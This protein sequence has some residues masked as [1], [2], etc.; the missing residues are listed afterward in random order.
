MS[1]QINPF[2]IFGLTPEIASRLDEKS[3][4]TLIKSLYRCLAKVYHPDL[5]GQSGQE[6]LAAKQAARTVE[7]NLA[8]EQLNLERDRD[9]FRRFHKAYANRTNRGQRKKIREL[10]KSLSQERRRQASLADGFVLY[11]LREMPWF[12]AS[13]GREAGPNLPSPAN[14]KLGLNDVAINHNIRGASWNLG[15]NYKEIIFDALGGMLYRPVGRSH[16]FSVNFIH[17]LGT[18]PVEEIDLVPLLNRMPPKEGFF[19]RAAL[20]SRYGMDGAPIEVLNTLS[21]D[22]FK[23]HCLSRLQPELRERS[24]LFSVHRPI[25]EETGDIS[26]E[27]VVVK[28]SGL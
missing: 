7:L 4:F 27:G 19:K 21:M 24:Y 12:A 22:K 28:I 18:V 9:S 5:T 3:L 26:L 10:E 1:G 6:G 14:I 16:P 17:L 25:F 13:N 2:E 11:L 20:D 8:F 23:E 15:S